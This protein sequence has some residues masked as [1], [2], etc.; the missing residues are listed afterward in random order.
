[1]T[2]L[3]GVEAGENRRVAWREMAV[4]ALPL[5]AALGPY[6]IPIP[7]GGVT[8]YAYR[9][10][11]LILATA[12]LL[13]F[14]RYDWWQI[15][16]ARAYAAVGGFWI[17]WASL[18]AFWAPSLER[19]LLE[20]A[21]LGFGFVTGITML[22]LG[23]HV[24][25]T[26]NALRRG[27]VLAF[28]ATGAVAGWEL[29]TGQHLPS[30]AVERAGPGG[31]QG[32]AISTFGNQNNYAAFLLL[33]APFLLWSH[34][35]SRSR[36]RRIFYTGCLVLLPALLFVTASRISLL[37]LIAEAGF[38]WLIAPRYR[39][40]LLVYLAVL[41]ALGFV[42]FYLLGLEGRMVY[43][44]SVMLGGS[45]FGGGGGS[46]SKRWN[47]MLAGLWLLVGSGGLGV[48]PGGF[49]AVLRQRLVPFDT[50]GLVNPHNFWIEVVSQYG[51]PVFG[52][53]V[54][55]ILYLAHKVNRKRRRSVLD[56][57]AFQTRQVA[58]TVLVGLVG[59]L[60]AA[61]ANSTYMVQST[62]WM[63]WASI[64]VMAAYLWRKRV[65]AVVPAGDAEQ[66]PTPEPTSDGGAHPGASGASSR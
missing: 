49:E 41:A 23:S 21:A 55:W 5:T 2:A 35:A 17:F 50:G 36:L 13:L 62:N 63:F 4:T 25:P 9:A 64:V 33:A 52:A 7:L 10:L 28:L 26:L 45:G 16:V 14:P 34:T 1:M 20:V 43:E 53:F 38:L 51:V 6:L 60:F 56:P 47:L 24:L 27:W 11:V 66:K 58:V 15:P 59:Y 44:L 12:S 46:V 48:G 37:G 32:I 65:V 42:V 3:G 30:S 8:L 18:A 29:A 61:V 54:L 22:Q 39:S 40:R 57:E 19:A 31:L